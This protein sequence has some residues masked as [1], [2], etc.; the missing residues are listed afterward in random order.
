MGSQLQST[1]GKNGLTFEATFP[2]SPSK[3]SKKMKKPGM[4]SFKECKPSLQ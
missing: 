1:A 4:P 2:N 3:M